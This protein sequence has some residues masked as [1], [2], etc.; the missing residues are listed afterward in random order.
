MKLAG[1]IA[2]FNERDSD[3]EWITKLA[4]QVMHQ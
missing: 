3:N 4:L 1:Y 2:G